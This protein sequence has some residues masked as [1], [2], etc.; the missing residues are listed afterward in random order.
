MLWLA[1]RFLGS[2]EWC[3]LSS[4]ILLTCK[5]PLRNPYGFLSRIRS[6]YPARNGVFLLVSDRVA[7]LHRGVPFLWCW[8]SAW[9]LGRKQKYLSKI[10]VLLWSFPAVKSSLQ[11][12]LLQQCLHASHRWY[13]DAW[14]ERRRWDKLGQMVPIHPWRWTGKRGA[15]GIFLQHSVLRTPKNAFSLSSCSFAVEILR[16][17][18]THLPWRERTAV[19]FLFFFILLCFLTAAVRKKISACFHQLNW[20]LQEIEQILPS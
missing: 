6:A 3:L 18:N 19:G 9:D 8:T 16:I 4:Y 20:R 17:S 1:V 13:S 2:Q 5:Q 11:F 15:K 14:A 10:A 12:P 7:L